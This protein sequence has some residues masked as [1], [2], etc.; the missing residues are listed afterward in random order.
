MEL[1]LA[2]AW[3]PAT[4]RLAGIVARVSSYSLTKVGLGLNPCKGRSPRRWAS[5]SCKTSETKL[6]FSFFELFVM[7]TVACRLSS[8]T[9]A[10]R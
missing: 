5:S 9:T 8:P 10:F 1:M 3:P 7:F 2:V 4:F 6:D